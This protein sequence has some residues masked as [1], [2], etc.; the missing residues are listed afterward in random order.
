M[1]TLIR[2]P[3]QAWIFLG[4]HLPEPIKR[5]WDL[6]TCTL[7][8][9]FMCLCLAPVIFALLVSE[10]WQL[11]ISYSCLSMA[12]LFLGFVADALKHL[13]RR[14]LYWRLTRLG[15]TFKTDVVFAP[16]SRVLARIGAVIVLIELP[17]LVAL[18]LPYIWEGVQLV[19]QAFAVGL[20]GMF[21]LPGLLFFLLMYEREERRA[22]DA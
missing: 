16:K 22:E 6:I 14:V 2:K 21:T 13:L 1:K 9:G 18:A 3:R 7:L 20:T 19:V 15:Y 11:A 17:I 10:R 8:A 4:S 12:L 5:V